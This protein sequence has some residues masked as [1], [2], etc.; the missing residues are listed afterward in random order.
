MAL[1]PDGVNTYVRFARFQVSAAPLAFSCT[2]ALGLWLPGTEPAFSR[3][4]W[5]G[6]G[7]S[8][9]GWQLPPGPQHTAR[10]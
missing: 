4:L 6:A 2:F 5:Q 8:G 7:A 9:V 3:H 1:D 10:R